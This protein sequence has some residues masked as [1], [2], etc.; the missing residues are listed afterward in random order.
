[1][2]I[3]VSVL[4]VLAAFVR[5]RWTILLALPVLLFPV[6]FLLDL[7]GWLSY[8]GNHL[9]PHAALSS[10]IKP[11]TPKVLGVGLI[12]QFKT[13]AVAGPGFWRAVDA[14]TVVAVGLVVH[15]VVRRFVKSGTEAGA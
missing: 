9:D 15:G 8:F 5:T 3:G 14:A 7:Q 4:L 12:G 1:M 10:S 6:V 13:I 2:L 11:F